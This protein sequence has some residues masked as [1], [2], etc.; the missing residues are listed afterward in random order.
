[1]DGE[2]NCSMNE[3][4]KLRQCEERTEQIRF[5]LITGEWME[6]EIVV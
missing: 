1:M 6:R 4:L 3:E 5:C 2:G